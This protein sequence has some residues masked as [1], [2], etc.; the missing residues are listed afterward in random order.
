MWDDEIDTA[1]R[2]ETEVRVPRDFRARV[3]ARIDA[4]YERSVWRPIG[5]S[6]AAAVP[7][8]VVLVVLLVNMRDRRDLG[9]RERVATDTGP[10]MAGQ[11]S[12]G[13]IGESTSRRPI[14]GP[15]ATR[16]PTRITEAVS[17]RRADQSHNP[18]L[19]NDL[20]NEGPSMPFL[21]PETRI[22]NEPLT[23][24]RLVTEFIA[25]DALEITPLDGQALSQ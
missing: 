15:L 12:A 2:A 10:T 17:D 9:P 14:D 23:T 7:V 21:M 8:V 6:S 1:A 13:P 5:L 3:L 19:T 16:E 22:T 4:R 11:Q 24:D 20:S 25:I 18:S